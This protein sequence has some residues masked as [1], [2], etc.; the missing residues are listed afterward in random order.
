MVKEASG[1]GLRHRPVA[2]ASL[3]VPTPQ[4]PPAAD[5]NSGLSAD[6][7]SS[8]RSPAVQLVDPEHPLYGVVGTTSALSIWTKY[9]HYVTV[10]GPVAAMR[11]TASNLMEDY[12]VWMHAYGRAAL[13]A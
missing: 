3:E 5:G 1:K 13:A 11:L 8:T 10:S 7:W 2:S 12:A 6:E 9:R 4:L